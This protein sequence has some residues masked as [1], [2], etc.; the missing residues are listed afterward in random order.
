M[1]SREEQQTERLSILHGCPY[2]DLVVIYSV[3]KCNEKGGLFTLLQL[4]PKMYL[5]ARKNINRLK[6]QIATKDRQLNH[7][8]FCEVL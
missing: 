4:F 7:N 3:M 6:E 1:R 8:S 2:F 5:E